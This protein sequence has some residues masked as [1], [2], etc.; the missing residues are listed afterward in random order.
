M[1]GALKKREEGESQQEYLFKLPF[2]KKK[3]KGLQK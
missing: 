3:S 2:L 1:E